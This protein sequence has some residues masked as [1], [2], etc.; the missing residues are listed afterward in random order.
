MK[1]GKAPA[2]AHVNLMYYKSGIKRKIWPSI[3][4]S[5]FDRNRLSIDPK[6]YENVKLLHMYGISQSSYQK[7]WPTRWYRLLV[8]IVLLKSL[9]A[10]WTF[11]AIDK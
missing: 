4:Q 6:S 9:Q 2:T 1:L 10:K 11:N 3:M 8:E 7:T 5:E